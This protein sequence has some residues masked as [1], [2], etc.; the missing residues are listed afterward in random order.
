MSE[1]IRD[2]SLTAGVTP[3]PYHEV[4]DIVMILKNTENVS[5]SQK[6]GEVTDFNMYLINQKL[7][8]NRFRDH[9]Q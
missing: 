7:C 4:C 2:C 8:K 1:N 3:W 6:L 5:E 9:V